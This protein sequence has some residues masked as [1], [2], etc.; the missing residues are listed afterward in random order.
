MLLATPF[1]TGPDYLGFVILLPY[2]VRAVQVGAAQARRQRRL[3]RRRRGHGHGHAGERLEQLRL[4]A[5]P[6]VIQRDARQVVV[7][8]HVQRH[9]LHSGVQQ[10]EELHHIIHRWFLRLGKSFFIHSEVV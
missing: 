7:F 2:Q 8:Q 10:S 4:T 5:L 9:T 6:A 3:G 1:R